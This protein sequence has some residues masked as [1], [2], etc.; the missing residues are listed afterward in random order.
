MSRDYFTWNGKTS[1][2]MGLVI[3]GEPRYITGQK[4]VDKYT[5]PGRNGSILFDTGA[6]SDG[7]AEY[8]VSLVSHTLE[9]DLY[10]ISA[11]LMGTT[12]YSVYKALT[13]TQ[14]PLIT[15]YA[16]CDNA[17]DFVR[18]LK[19]TGKG[20]IHF[21]C[22]PQRYFSDTLSAYETLSGSGVGIVNNY[23][24]ARP[25]ITVAGSGAGVLKVG[26]VQMTFSDIPATLTIDCE[27]CLTYAGNNN[28]SNLVT[29]SGYDYPELH[30]GTTVI[31][32]SGGITQVKVCKRLWTL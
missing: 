30:N 3:E 23:M 20:T 4:I 8:T 26:N 27:N 14:E 15:R 29:L 31:T 21:C 7:E 5:V 1:L 16:Y 10:L 9:A 19:I 18:K 17:L 28:Y 22:K 24:P 32:Y 11:W 12:G 13:D 25:Y 2:Q 6:Y